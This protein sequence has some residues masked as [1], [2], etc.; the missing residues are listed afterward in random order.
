MVEFGLPPM[1]ALVAATSNAAKLLRM[2]D[3]IGSVEKGKVADLILVPG[4]PLKDI[5]AMRGPAFVMKSGKVVHDQVRQ[6]VAAA[7]VGTT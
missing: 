2:D 1:L 4:D 5:G 6:A 3:Q 7:E